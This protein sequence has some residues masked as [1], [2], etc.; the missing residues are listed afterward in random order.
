M[1][2][3]KTAPTSAQNTSIAMPNNI[4]KDELRQ[5]IV[6]AV[7]EIDKLREKAEE[8]K[9]K[10]SKAEWQAAI[11]YKDFSGEKNRFRR[12][13]KRFINDI[14]VGFKVFFISGKKVKGNSFTTGLL[15]MFLSLCF[16][17][18]QIAFIIVATSL[19]IVAF[20]MARNDIAQN[21]S[22][23]FMI[24]GLVFL[25]CLFS[26]FFRL[27]SLEIENTKD[28]NF[29]VGVFAGIAAILSVIVAVI[30][31]LRM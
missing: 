4:S 28:N 15:K 29:L 11:G 17:A 19:I 8:V 20:D 31:L 7:L 27:A 24:I 2:K 13:L 3:K 5:I 25:A 26:T 18:V 12:G 23:I 6:D 16:R 21:I 14:A 22:N 10:E 1:K 9:E 30:T